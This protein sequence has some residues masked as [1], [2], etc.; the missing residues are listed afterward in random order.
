MQEMKNTFGTSMTTGKSS[1][2]TDELYSFQVQLSQVRS[3]CQTLVKMFDVKL[4]SPK[5]SEKSS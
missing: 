2:S 3:I 5:A 1:L 4:N